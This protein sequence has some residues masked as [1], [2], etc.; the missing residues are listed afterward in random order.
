[1]E[2]LAVALEKDREFNPASGDVVSCGV[3]RQQVRD[4]DDADEDLVRVSAA[5]LQLAGAP[6]PLGSDDDTRGEGLLPRQGSQ[7][8]D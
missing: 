7:M 6:Q 3:G 4:E 1:M 2:D 8:V 5:L